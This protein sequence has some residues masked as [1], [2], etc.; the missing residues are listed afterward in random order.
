MVNMPLAPQLIT[1]VSPGEDLDDLSEFIGPELATL[2]SA[3]QDKSITILQNPDMNTWYS[4]M[5][6]HV[7]YES[8]DFGKVLGEY[9]ANDNQHNPNNIGAH[10]GIP[11][12]TFRKVIIARKI[13]GGGAGGVAGGGP[14]LPMVRTEDNNNN[15]NSSSDMIRNDFVTGNLESGSK[16]LLLQH[17]DNRSDTSVP[18]PSVVSSKTASGEGVTLTVVRGDPVSGRGVS[19][20]G[21][22]GAYGAHLARRHQLAHLISDKSGEVKRC[23]VTKT[24]S[25]PSIKQEPLEDPNQSMVPDSSSDLRQQSGPGGRQK[26]GHYHHRVKTEFEVKQE[27][28]WDGEMKMEGSS[29]PSSSS[30]H[31]VLE[32]LN[33]GKTD[34]KLETGDLPSLGEDDIHNVIGSCKYYLKQKTQF[35]MILKPILCSNFSRLP[36]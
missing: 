28:S 17:R 22:V 2:V 19:V 16:A 5:S 31:V 20:S 35:N 11:N 33:G 24:I 4:D 18:G 9:A 21:P 29:T 23:G 7:N 6:G 1:E 8:S 25:P 26:N 36:E 10:G 12:Q 34:K 15:N 3:T 30:N 14:Q 13:G 32:R 27:P